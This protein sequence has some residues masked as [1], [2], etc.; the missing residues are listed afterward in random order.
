[1]SSNNGYG[2]DMPRGVSDNGRNNATEARVSGGPSYRRQ[3]CQGSNGVKY[4]DRI[5]RVKDG[6]MDLLYGNPA[7]NIQ[8]LTNDKVIG[9]S[10]FSGIRGF[11]QVPARRLDAI[12]DG[13]TQR[14]ILIETIGSLVASS[15]TPT[16]RAYAEVGAYMLGTTTLGVAYSGALQ[17]FA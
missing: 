15:T 12:V 17:L 2:C 6:M 7:L 3:W 9:L 5:T 1:T 10:T 11:I 16:A 4:Y 8:P 14:Q 13:Q